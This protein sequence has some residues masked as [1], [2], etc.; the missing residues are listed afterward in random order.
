MTSDYNLRSRCHAKV[1]R[2]SL[3]VARRATT[4]ARMSREGCSP[5]NPSY[6]CRD[7]RS[8]SPP[9]Q[10]PGADMHRWHRTGILAAA[11]TLALTAGAFAQR[12]TADITG[13]VT[14]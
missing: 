14:D 4:F 13:T 12:T 10:R 2:R 11:L 8:H 9:H 3:N 5:Q 1:A 6:G 7:N